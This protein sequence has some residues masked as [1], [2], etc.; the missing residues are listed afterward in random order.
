[1]ESLNFQSPV[2]LE[3]G[4]SAWVKEAK[5]PPAKDAKP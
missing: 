3:G 2:N 1:L 5:Q 4:Y